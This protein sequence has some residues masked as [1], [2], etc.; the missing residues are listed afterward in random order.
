[1]LQRLHIARRPRNDQI[2]GQ[3][4]EGTWCPGL[5]VPGTG[6][7]IF[8]HYG[9]KVKKCL[10][11]NTIRGNMKHGKE[12]RGNKNMKNKALGRDL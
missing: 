8:V 5:G 10:T 9:E 6:C 3:K 12:K 2:H 4:K 7:P 11:C 1:M